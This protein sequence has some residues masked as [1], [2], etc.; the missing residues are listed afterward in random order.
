MPDPGTLPAPPNPGKSATRKALD[1]VVPRCLDGI[2]HTCWSQPPDDSPTTSGL[3]PQFAKNMEVGD[4]YLKARNFAGAESR[5]REALQIMPRNP[6]ANFKLAQSLDRLHKTDEA[7]QNYQ[8]YLALQPA[9]LFA[10]DASQALH[11]LEKRAGPVSR[12]PH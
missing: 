6:E 1:K 12:K 4:F 10:K 5:F 2:F 9:G 11:R 3:D 8:L 7:R